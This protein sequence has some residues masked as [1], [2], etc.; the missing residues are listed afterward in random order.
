MIHL[1]FSFNR[2]PL[3]FVI[4]GREI[5]YTQRK[6]ARGSWVRC[7]P[8]PKNFLRIIALSR[9]KIPSFL[10]EMFNFTDEE[11]KEYN[12]AKDEEA[13]AQIIIRDAKGK[14][15]IFVSLKKVEEEEEVSEPEKLK[16]EKQKIGEEKICHKDN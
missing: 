2:E 15:C 16:I 13:L 3:N 14:A 12:E 1:A 7:M 4:K 8:P 5:F 10:S 6:F 11:I 9:N